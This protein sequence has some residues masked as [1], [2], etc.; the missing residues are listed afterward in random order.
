MYNLFLLAYNSCTG[1]FIVALVI[2]ERASLYAPAS[3]DH[4]PPICAFQHSWDDRHMQLCPA[5]G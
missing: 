1:G 3:L 2:L 5:I 4:D